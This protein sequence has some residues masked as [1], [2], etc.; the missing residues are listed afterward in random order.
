MIL[1]LLTFMTFSQKLLQSSLSVD[2]P[3]K[4]R[5]N[6][7]LCHFGAGAVRFISVSRSTLT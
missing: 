1:E 2:I 6:L 5:Q 3:L 7:F 4:N